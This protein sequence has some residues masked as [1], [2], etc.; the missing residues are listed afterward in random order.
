MAYYRDHGV[1]LTVLRRARR[2]YRK[3]FNRLLSLKLTG[4]RGINVHPS[5]LLL[6]LQ[7][8]SIGTSFRAGLHFRL[9]AF[10]RHGSQTFTPRVV[11]KDNVEIQDF[12]HIGVTNYV[13]IGNNV[14]IASKVYISDHNHGFY[15]GEQQSDPEVPPSERPID[16][17]RKVVIEDNVWLGEFVSVMPGVTIGRGSIIGA[18]SVVTRDIPPY[19]LA[20]GTPARVVK[21]YDP[22]VRR[23]EQV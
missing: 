17:R 5:C 18:N 16:F 11:I 3:L 15:A 6:G 23:W 8:M 20:V 4:A 1:A 22:Q 14:L 2:L 21:R 13:E 12:V 10:S 7:H 19:S 9:E